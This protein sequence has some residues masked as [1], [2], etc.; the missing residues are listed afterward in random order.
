LV[1]TRS[2]GID[3]ST[4]LWKAW[5]N[6]EFVMHYQPQ[7]NLS[8]G[9]IEK[10][11]SLIRWNYKGKP[12][13]PEI[14]IPIAEEIGLIVPLGQWIMQTVCRQLKKWQEAC[15]DFCGV[16]VN[17]SAHQLQDPEVI[18]DM[19][20]AM[21]ECKIA[22]GLIELELT[23]R[24]YMDNQENTSHIFGQLRQRGISVAIDDFGTGYSSLNSLQYIP[25][26]TLK[27][28][29]SFVSNLQKNKKSRVI[30][31]AILSLADSLQVRAVAEGVETRAQ[32]DFLKQAGCQAI[33][34][35]FYSKAV[36][37]E[38]AYQLYIHRLKN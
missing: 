36:S 9:L 35:Y 19:I 38:E 33:Q 21:D 30:T 10:F 32:F 17:V 15:P 22:P 13:S 1:I 7:V 29:R 14:F 2:T 28:D 6:R 34:G 24:V 37:A 20:L 8:T 11:E 25:F 26:D 23:E 12:V 18:E 3:L 5:E 27:I 16:S 31:K 4:E